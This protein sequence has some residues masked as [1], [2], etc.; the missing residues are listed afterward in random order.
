MDNN[1]Y[2]P[3]SSDLKKNQLHRFHII[4][5]CISI[6]LALYGASFASLKLVD[7]YENWW[8]FTSLPPQMLISS[9]YYL[10][11][12]QIETLGLVL[13]CYFLFK[14]YPRKCAKIYSIC[15]VTAILQEIWVSTGIWAAPFNIF[16]LLPVPVYILM[17][18]YFSHVK[19]YYKEP[20]KRIILSK[21][22]MLHANVLDEKNIKY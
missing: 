15:I 17:A 12:Y 3:P 22:R 21:S 19:K 2:S 16:I 20:Q 11:I 9:L 4:I 7:F 18:A 10:L 5:V 13:A 6:L 8:F 1:I 14:R